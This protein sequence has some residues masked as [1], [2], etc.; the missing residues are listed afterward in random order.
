MRLT[1]TTPTPVVPKLW[2]LEPV[3]G[4]R[5]TPGPLTVLPC[6]SAN[7][8][9]SFLLIAMLFVISLGLLIGVVKVRARSGQASGCQDL[10]A[11]HDPSYPP[12]PSSIHTHCGGGSAGWQE[13]GR[14]VF[15]ETP[16]CTLELFML[17]YSLESIVS[18]PDFSGWSPCFRANAYPPGCGCARAYFGCSSW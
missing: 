7:L 11:G 16:R 1:V 12:A 18:I 6:L 5:G 2:S 15:W 13:G 4:C 8:V 14:W 9:S 17:A 3:W 10:G